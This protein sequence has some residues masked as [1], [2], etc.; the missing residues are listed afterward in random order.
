M[1][2][3]DGDLVR[4]D[5]GLSGRVIHV[6]RLTAFVEL[7]LEGGKEV[8]PI[9]LSELSRVDPPQSPTGPTVRDHVTQD[10]N[11]PPSAH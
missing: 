6:S 3:K 4:T 9:L 8:V 1:Q 2:I 10:E 5:S 11:N 7:D